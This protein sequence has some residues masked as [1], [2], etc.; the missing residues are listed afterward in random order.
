[1][2]PTADS[3]KGHL[4]LGAAAVH[5]SGSYDSVRALTFLMQRVVAVVALIALILLSGCTRRKTTPPPTGGALVNVQMPPAVPGCYTYNPNPVDRHANPWT[6]GKCLTPR[7]VSRLPHLQPGVTASSQLGPPTPCVGTCGAAG[8][9]PP[10]VTMGSVSVSLAPSS[11]Q[12]T[13]SLFQIVDTCISQQCQNIANSQSGC[14][15]GCVETGTGRFSFSVQ[16][17]TNAYPIVCNAGL[18]A[19]AG[20]TC[21]NGDQG[22]VQFSYQWDIGGYCFLCNGAQSALCIGMVDLSLANGNS[23]NSGG[24]QL[25]CAGP[26]DIG[27]NPSIAWWASPNQAITLTAFHSTGDNNQPMLMLFG[28]F[29]WAVPQGEQSCL[30]AVV[31]PDF[32]GLCSSPTTSNCQ[33]NQMTGS[34]FGYGSASTAV[35]P[36]GTVMETEVA[37]TG[38]VP[39]PPYLLGYTPPPAFTDLGIFP[40]NFFG[41]TVPPFGG[42]PCTGSFTSYISPPYTTGWTKDALAIADAAGFAG[43]TGE[44][45]NLNPPNNPSAIPQP[46]IIPA[47]F[48]GSCWIDYQSTN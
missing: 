43:A 6:Q 28:C 15:F 12:S 30:T 48:A 33:W 29:P 26:P 24:F 18:A 42:P 8:A 13:Y 38:C 1:M 21:V 19:Q 11:N 31:V 17:N 7:Q 46:P 40:G 23:A 35:F 9:N 4:R 37:A 20:S 25:T 27:F 44:S 16:A 2:I 22:W 5:I 39:I 32:T 34:L 47:C 3:G 10:Q 14:V 45:N 36:S 41:A